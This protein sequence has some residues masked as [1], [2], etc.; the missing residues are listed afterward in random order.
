MQST[1]LPPR[2]VN[3]IALQPRRG[4]GL[5]GDSFFP[6]PRYLAEGRGSTFPTDSRGRFWPCARPLGWRSHVGCHGRPS[7]LHRNG[8]DVFCGREGNGGD[9]IRTRE[10]R[11]SL[12]N[13]DRAYRIVSPVQ[14]TTLPPRPVNEIALQPRRGFG[15]QGDSFFP[16][17]RYPAEGCGSTF[18]TDAR[19]RIWPCARPLGGA[20]LDAMDGHPEGD[21]DLSATGRGSGRSR[22]VG[23]GLLLVAG[24]A[25]MQ[26]CGDSSTAPS[27]SPPRPTSC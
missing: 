22:A 13:E 24:A 18:P 3:E 11:A 15:L 9:G 8:S 25:L 19:G 4:F 26:S 17:P 27:R 14:S 10:T 5:Q 16:P 12:Q 21:A 2:P 23:L 1:T 7:G 6:P 20:T